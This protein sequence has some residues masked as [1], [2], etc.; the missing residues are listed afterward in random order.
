MF[1]LIDLC[2]VMTFKLIDQENVPIIDIIEIIV[3]QKLFSSGN[4]VIDLIAVVDVHIHCFFI[5][6]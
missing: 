6:I 1:L 3:D 2:Q 4:R 5:V